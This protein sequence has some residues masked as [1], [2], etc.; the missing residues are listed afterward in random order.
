M[1]KPPTF[2]EGNDEERADAKR[3]YQT[4]TLKRYGDVKALTM[5][6]GKNTKT[7]D[8]GGMGLKTG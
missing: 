3:P 6:V 1:R 4:P 2:R 5:A 7:D 8:G